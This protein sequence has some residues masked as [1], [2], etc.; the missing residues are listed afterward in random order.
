LTPRA[1]ATYRSPMST[2]VRCI[3][4]WGLCAGLL[5]LGCAAEDPDGMG[6]PQGSDSSSSTVA[7]ADSSATT[8]S[9]E[10]TSSS[11]VGD[12]TTGDDDPSATDSASAE[13]SSSGEGDGDSGSSETGSGVAYDEEFLWVA[14]FLRTNCVSCHTN[15]KNGALLLPTPDITNEEIRLALDGVVANTGLLLVEPSDRQASQTYLQITNEF[16]AIFPVEET[17]RFGEWI[18]AGAL[19]YAP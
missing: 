6:E 15:G 19:Y 4:S 7:S 2:I 16:G 5:A 14:D 9:P 18:D 10:G 17:D 3:G 13:G 11:G 12:V 1:T 8:P